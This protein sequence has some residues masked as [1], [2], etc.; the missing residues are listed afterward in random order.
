MQIDNIHST[1]MLIDNR[2]KSDKIETLL[3]TNIQKCIQWCIKYDMLYNNIPVNVNVFTSDTMNDA[4]RQS[5][6]SR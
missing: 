6:F 5:S 3:K 1:L 2:F 4:R